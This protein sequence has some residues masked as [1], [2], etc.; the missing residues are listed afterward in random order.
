[1][2]TVS[3]DRET[4]RAGP[5]VAFGATNVDA[6]A[7]TIEEDLAGGQGKERVVASLTHVAA[8]MPFGSPLAD[9]NIAREDQFAAKLLDSQPLCVRI[10][11]VAGGA[12]S[13]LVSHA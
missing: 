9:Q 7:A 2:N 12:L 8:R 10:A 1:M 5:S 11:A 3:S 6:A 4:M 13:L